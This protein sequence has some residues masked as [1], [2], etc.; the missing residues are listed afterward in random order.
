MKRKIIKQ[1]HNTLTITLP[2]EW[3]KNLNLKAGDELNIYEKDN[4]LVLNGDEKVREKSAVLDINDFT[5]PL[6][7]RFFQGM[8]RAGCDEIKIIFNENT[9][10]YEDPYHYYTTQFDYAE[11]G[12][13][14]PPKPLL[15]AIQSLVDRFV[16]LEIIDSR[17]GYIIVR[18]MGEVTTKEFDNS[19]RRIFLVVFQL[20]DRIIEAVKKNE[21][22]DRNLCKDIH[23]IDLNI[24]RFVDYC[25]RILNKINTTPSEKNKSLLFSSLFL[26]E[27]LGDE[28][29]YIGKHLAVSKKPVKEC[30]SLAEKV[31]EHFDIYYNLFYKFNREEAI[32]FGKNDKSIYE[33]HHYKFK[34]KTGQERSIARHLMMISKFTLALAELRIEMEY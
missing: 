13:K 21:I 9:R 6:L 11:L 33:E 19:L 2:S 7:W 25:C 31:K 23:T 30:L 29:K 10:L 17:K 15:V 1:G 18:E 22:N 28:F 3:V 27:L 32:K 34:N 12:E 5:V 26:L 16:G 4:S 8:Y 20:F 14:I 24:D